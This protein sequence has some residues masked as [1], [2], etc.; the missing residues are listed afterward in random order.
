MRR[1]LNNFSSAL[2]KQHP[3]YVCRVVSEEGNIGRRHLSNFQELEK[4][5]PAI[6]T[7][8]K[9][10]TTG[11]DIPTCKNIVIAKVI[12]SMTDFKQTIGRGSRIRDDYGKYYFTILDYT[13]SATRLFSDP[14]FDGEPVR[15]IEEWRKEYNHIRPHSA[16]NYRP[17]A[18]ET[19]I[20]LTLT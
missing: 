18:P 5:T 13:G 19:I 4:S 16:L 2:V 9:L 15:I 3:D 1:A 6:L 20:P 7:T 12:N 17:P 11:V 14:D 8:S 10:L